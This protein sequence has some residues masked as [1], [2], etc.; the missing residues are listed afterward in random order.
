LT[1]AAGLFGLLA[2]A[3]LAAGLGWHVRRRAGRGRAA[4][5]GTTARTDASGILKAIC[6]ACGKHLKAPATLAGKKVKCP[7]CGVIRL[8]PDAAKR[9][10]PTPADSGCPG[11][12]RWRVGAAAALFLLLVGGGLFL[13]VPRRP[14]A[15]FLNV[16]LGREEVD[17]VEE[18]GFG[19]TEFDNLQRPFRWTDGRARLIIPLNKGK[20]PRALVVQLPPSRPAHAPPATLQ[21]IVNEKVLFQDEVP[22]GA[23]DR[24][25]DLDPAVLGDKLTLDI[26]SNTFVPQALPG[27]TSGDTR[28]LGVCVSCIQL[29][30]PA[31]EAK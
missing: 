31:E 9:P 17:G 19:N 14:A 25:F 24:T 12:T 16:P 15:A 6:V 29:L 4:D 18:S 7:R 21:V 2:V 20:L 5:A 10:A 8:L 23:L 22:N 13:L 27:S 1:A 3:G 28:A 11:P 30:G 26:L